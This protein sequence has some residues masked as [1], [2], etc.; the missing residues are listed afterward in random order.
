MLCGTNLRRFLGLRDFIEGGRGNGIVT[1]QEISDGSRRAY[2]Q[3]WETDVRIV[4]LV[5][6]GR[7]VV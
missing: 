7:R 2:K 6:P 4:E 5:K 1:G 3:G